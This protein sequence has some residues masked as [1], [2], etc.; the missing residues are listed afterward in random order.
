MNKL[1]LAYP[2]PWQ[3]VTELRAKNEQLQGMCARLAHDAGEKQR[4]VIRL[5]AALEAVEWITD[6][7]GVRWCPSCRA[8]HPEHVSNCKLRAALDREQ[9]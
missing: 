4:E 9:P 1:D 5:R 8:C 3:L 2:N 7:D 6:Y